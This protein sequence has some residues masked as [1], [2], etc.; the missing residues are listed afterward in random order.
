MKR[1]LPPHHPQLQKV[2]GKDQRQYSL[3]RNSDQ[4]RFDWAN[5]ETVSVITSPSSNPRSYGHDNNT[6]NRRRSRITDDE[7]E[8]ERFLD[9][10]HQNLQALCQ[11]LPI[12]KR[13]RN[14][15]SSAN[16]CQSNSIDHNIT[17]T[18][19]SSCDSMEVEC[20]WYPQPS[21]QSEDEILTQVST[22]LILAAW[23]VIKSMDSTVSWTDQILS[24]S[25]PVFFV[26]NAHIHMN[27]TNENNDN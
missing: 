9:E 6:N 7:Y 3:L 14:D 22:R 8:Q 10:K 5:M 18:S 4:N 13:Y 15:E 24:L 11:S 21:I 23:T 16:A 26:H 2:S 19:S 25:I 1:N 17:T 27:T 12:T 20:S